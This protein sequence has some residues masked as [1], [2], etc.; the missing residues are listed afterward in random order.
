MRT[1]RG[2]ETNLIY[3]V[4]FLLFFLDLFGSVNLAA[5]YTDRISIV[6]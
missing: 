1:P 4:I 5:E 6:G 2:I 3:G